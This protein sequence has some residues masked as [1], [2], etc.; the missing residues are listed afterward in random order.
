MIGRGHWH[1]V[2]GLLVGLGAAGCGTPA[3]RRAPPQ[4]DTAFT[5]SAEAGVAAL[6]WGDLDQAGKRFADAL[7]R[8]RAMNRD[9]DIAFAAYHAASVA[10]SS[11]DFA[12]AGAL[13]A[14]AHHAYRATGRD[15]A[16]LWL[17]DA[18]VARARSQDDRFDGS[19]RRA[20]AGADHRVRAF[21]RYL[22]AH[23]ALEAGDAAGARELVEGAGTSEWSVPELVEVA[24]MIAESDDPGEAASYYD[25]AAAAYQDAGRA[26]EMAATLERAGTAHLASGDEDAAVD[27]YYRA[28][29][30]FHGRGDARLAK[31]AAAS[32]L[33][34]LGDDE[35]ELRRLMEALA[36]G[37]DESS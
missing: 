17:L 18:R 16:E 37:D 10:F 24:G 22:L 27:R 31:K 33:E 11:G 36:E 15:A 9:A 35:H 29:R 26:R 32:G 7:Q 19:A 30:S 21:A 14:E 28:A 6:G 8:A 2:L 20:L 23:Q 34:I 5:A 12:A 3:P 4:G 13:L 25:R 1:A